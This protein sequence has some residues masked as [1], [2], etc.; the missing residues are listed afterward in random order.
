MKNW[1]EWYIAALAVVLA[2]LSFI[3]GALD[4]VS[5][6][7]LGVVLIILAALQGKRQ[8]QQA[9]VAAAP[10]DAN[11]KSAKRW[12]IFEYGVGLYFAIAIAG[13]GLYVLWSAVIS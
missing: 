10:T 9:L 8:R 1:N 4:L 12:R 2:A 7:Y 6:F 11:K 5:S 13:F 3:T